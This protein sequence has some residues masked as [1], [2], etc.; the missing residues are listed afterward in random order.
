MIVTTWFLLMCTAYRDMICMPKQEFRTQRECLFIGRNY[1][2]MIKQ[3][4]STIV[5]AAKCVSIS[6]KET[7]Q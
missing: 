7:R 5:V 3:T 4:D 6:R 1:E 2:S